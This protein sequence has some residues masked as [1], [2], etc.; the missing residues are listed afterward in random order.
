MV[1]SSNDKDILVRAHSVHSVTNHSNSNQQHH[2]GYGS[3]TA[4]DLAFLT[5]NYD[6]PLI[7]IQFTELH[8]NT[9]DVVIQWKVVMGTHT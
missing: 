4:L 8:Y 2:L 9:S 6:D 3:M 5:N 1:S 7:H